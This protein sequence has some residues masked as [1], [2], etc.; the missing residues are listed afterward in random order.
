MNARFTSIEKINQIGSRLHVWGNSCAGKSTLAENIGQALDIPVVELDALNWEADWVSVRDTNPEEFINRVTGACKGD[1]W[2]V[3]GSYSHTSL[4]HIW[5]KVQTVIWLDLP[6]WLLM[7]RVFRRCWKRARSG[8]L[9]WGKVQERFLPNL[10]VWRKEDSI[11]WWVWTQHKRKR[12]ELMGYTLEP[13]FGHIQFLRFTSAK[14]A[15]AWLESI[16]KD[17]K[18][19]TRSE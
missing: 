8:E 18:N 19:G 10:M 4:E 1:R 12:H 9:L 6:R 14:A 3:A 15:D 7:L 11:I 2:V 13:Q 16:R 17:Y 5:P